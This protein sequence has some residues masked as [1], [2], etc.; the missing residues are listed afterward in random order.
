MARRKSAAEQKA[1]NPN[2]FQDQPTPIVR[3]MF[4][5]PKRFKA[6]TSFDIHMVKLQDTV[7]GKEVLVP[8]QAYGEV[9]LVLG[10][11][12]GGADEG[13]FEHTPEG[14]W[15]APGPVP[16]FP[17]LSATTP[18][19][20]PE[21]TDTTKATKAAKAPAEA[22]SPAPTTSPP[23]IRPEGWEA[24]IKD[25]GYQATYRPPSKG[26]SQGYDVTVKGKVVALVTTGSAG[27]LVLA[28]TDG[29]FS[30]TVHRNIMGVKSRLDVLFE[31]D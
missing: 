20:P 5:L 27:R 22:V 25:Q 29:S 30:Q 26:V 7:N 23:A 15:S 9:R 31:V 19:N 28:S 12:F 16:S 4:T 10:T 2:L 17:E 13:T 18:D 6:S 24:V 1:P 3:R 8:A 21:P 14:P 11:F